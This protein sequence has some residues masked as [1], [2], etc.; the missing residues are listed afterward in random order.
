VTRTGRLV[1]IPSVTDRSNARHNTHT[2]TDANLADLCG[3][4][5]LASGRL[6]LLP[7]GHTGGCDFRPENDIQAAIDLR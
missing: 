7:A 3:M 5:H 4:T 2:N 1:N 6:C